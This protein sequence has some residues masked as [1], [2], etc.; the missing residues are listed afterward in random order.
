MDE[1]GIES[2]QAPESAVTE[3]PRNSRA[4]LYIVIGAVVAVALAAVGATLVINARNAQAEAD[5][6]EDH[7]MYQFSRAANGC[8]IDP[9]SR[10]QLDGGDAFNLP[11]ATKS[12]GATVAEVHCFLEE[13]GAPESLKTKLG[14]TRALDGTQSA[15]WAEF[16]ATWTYHPDSGLNLLVERVG[17]PVLP[18][19]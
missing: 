18:E 8:G 2:A 11:R 16:E 7:R 15:S 13:L 4:K 3:K 9:S 14:Q 10:E 17:E 1:S 19:N 5:R 12:D 6:L